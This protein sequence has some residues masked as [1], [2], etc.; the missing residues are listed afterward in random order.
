[1]A[2]ALDSLPSFVLAIFLLTFLATQFG[3][4]PP[5][6]YSYAWENPARHLQ[7]MILPALIVS[8][9]AS[10]NLVRLARTFF[11]EVI[12]QDYIRTARSKGLAERTILTRH[13]LRNVSLPFV[14]ILGAEIPALLTSSAIIENLFSLPGMGRYLVTASQKLDYPVVMT[15]TML[16]AIIA[17]TANLITDLSYAWLDPR[18]SYGR[19]NGAP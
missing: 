3:W 4:A 8:I 5:V 1:V 18:V 16:F 12:R 10:G 11:L 6:S 15:T 14:T 9:A 2:Y 13:A 17:L 7:I 19:R